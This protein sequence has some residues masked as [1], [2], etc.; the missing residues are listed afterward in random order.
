MDVMLC[1]APSRSSATVF[2]PA[3][4]PMDVVSGSMQKISQSSCQP[5]FQWMLCLAPPRSSAT[6]FL[7]ARLPMDVVSGSTQKLSHSLPASQ[8]SNG[9][10]VWLHPEAQPQS[11][12]QPGFQW[13]LCLAPHRSSATVFLPARLPMDVVSGST[14]KLSHSL[15]ASQ[16]SNGCCAWLHA[17]AQPQSSCQPGFQWMLCL[18]PCRSS[19]TVFLPARLPMDVVSGST[20]KLSHSLPA[21][22][23]SNGCCVWL[24]AEARPVF[25][26]A[27]LPMDVV[28][29][30]MQKLSHSLPASQ[31]SNGCCV[32]LHTE[33]QPQSSCQPGFQ[34]MLCLAPHRSSATVFLPVSLPMDVVP[35]STQKLSHSLPASQASNG[36]CVGLHTEAQPQSSCQ[37]GFQWM[38]CLAPCRS[39]ATVFLPARLPM[40]VVSGSKQK[41]SHSLPASQASNGCCVWL[42]AEAQPVFLPARLPMDV[43]SGSTQKLSHSL[44]ASQASNGCCVW[45]HT[46]AQ[47]Q[48]SCQPGFQ[49]M[50]CLAPPRSSATVFLPARLPMDV[51]SGSTQKLSHSLPASQASNGCC[52]WLHPEAQPQSSCQPG[53]QWMLCLAP[54]RSSVT[55][56]LPT[57]LPMDVVSGSMQ[58]LGQSSN[59]C[60][61]WLHAEAQPQSSCQPGFQWML[62]LATHRSSA[63]VFLPA[64]LPMDVVSGSTQKLSHSLPASEPS[65]GCCAWLHTEAQPQSSCQPGFQ[66]MLCRAPHRS[67]ATVFLPARLPMD[68]VSGSMQKLGQSSCQPGFQWMLCLAPWRSSASL[69][70]SQA[71]NG[72]CAWLQAEAQ[73][74]SSCQ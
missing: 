66:R 10:C 12:C 57:R 54:H 73:P 28:S 48:S 53:F 38:L 39:S 61:V 44:P 21:S 22:Q 50:L 49:W 24:H 46:E 7:P 40:D 4:L 20:Q 58:K 14:Q 37:P 34:W 74:Q 36:C 15:P 30:S 56:F 5:G 55:V 18:A 33:A 1:L 43:V 6:V 11:S 60:C 67:S 42:H 45:L 64:R 8:A 27:R 13:M 47:P 62:C 16:A 70:A 23:A 17:E 31:A 52:V 41:L 32:W 71:S 72:C 19:A 65:N 25:L 59:G 51:V 3:R 9:C 26:P 63:T 35:G 69:P 68:V 29:G 2:L